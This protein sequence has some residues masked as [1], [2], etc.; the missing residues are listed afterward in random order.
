MALLK[1]KNYDGMMDL[2]HPALFEKIDKQVLIN[3]FKT[4]LEGNEEFKIEVADV[5]ANAFNVSEI[6]TSK[7]NG[8]FAFVIYPMKMKMS[9]LKEKFDDERKKMMMNMMEVQGMKSK[10]TD[11][12]TLEMSKE[13]MIIAVNDKTT[14]NMWKYINYDEANP[15][16]AS[17]MSVEIMK[18]A[19]EYYA[20]FLIKQKE[21]AN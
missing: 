13:S 17:I 1:D 12:S 10:F 5:N 18:M 11:D 7:E 9:F 8:K 2:T 20:N 21:N 4:M 3:T 15:L 16:F 19:K 14:H 6:F